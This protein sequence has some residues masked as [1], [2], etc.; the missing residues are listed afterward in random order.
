M[1]FVIVMGVVA[2]RFFRLESKPGLEVMA[3]VDRIVLS[4]MREKVDVGID[5]DKNGGDDDDEAVEFGLA[6]AMEGERGGGRDPKRELEPGV[7]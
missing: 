2:T 1:E 3:D 7:V 6:I 4:A 5:G